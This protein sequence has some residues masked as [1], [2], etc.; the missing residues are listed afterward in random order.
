[1]AGRFAE[2]LP[3][4][5]IKQFGD[6][7]LGRLVDPLGG[8]A[9]PPPDDGRSDAENRAI[10]EAVEA[11]RTECERQRAEDKADFD[12]RL[13]EVRQQLTEEFADALAGRVTAA[14]AE[15]SGAISAHVAA[16]LS[17]FLDGA[18]RHRALDELCETVSA[19][20]VENR[21]AR[22]RIVG[23]EPLLAR[24]KQRLSALGDAIEYA[25]AGGADVTVRIDDTV[26]ETRIAAW[27]ERLAAAAGVSDV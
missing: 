17:R 25:E 4:F 14:L 19:L 18:V 16:V 20:V 8:P 5:A 27:A 7:A 1:M 22:V 15:M 23:P 3:H 24:L 10:R 26:I 9:A 21:A 2:H 12:M 13:A 11:A 6:V